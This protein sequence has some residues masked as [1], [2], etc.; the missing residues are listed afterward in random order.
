MRIVTQVKALYIQGKKVPVKR[1]VE[2]LDHNTERRSSTCLEES[3]ERALQF[4]FVLQY[5]LLLT[6]QETSVKTMRSN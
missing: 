5:S 4:P 2:F 3:R 1:F 6:A